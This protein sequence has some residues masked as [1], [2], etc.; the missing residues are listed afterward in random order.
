VV[1][2][3][4]WPRARPAG[5]PR[6]NE[7]RRKIA[8][9]EALGRSDEAQELPLAVLLFNPVDH[10]PVLP[11]ITSNARSLPEEWGRLRS[12]PSQVVAERN[13]MPLL[14]LPVLVNWPPYRRGRPLRESRTG[15]VGRGSLRT[16]TGTG[17]RT[18]SAPAIPLA[19][20]AAVAGH[21]GLRP[22][23]MGE[24]SGTATPAEHHAQSATKLVLAVSTTG[25]G[26]RITKRFVSRLPQPSGEWS[27]GQIVGALT[28]Q[29][30]RCSQAGCFGR[31]GPRHGYGFR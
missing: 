27:F 1:L 24:P 15:G 8:V 6:L 14:A 28:D 9:L 18:P 19:R 5:I 20:H 13:P 16:S 2:D 22:V 17:R 10:T 26:M 31:S 30:S 4:R 23:P 29:G 11:P 25:K 12:G 7:N 3:W 21:G